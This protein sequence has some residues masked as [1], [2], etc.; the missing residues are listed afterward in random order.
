MKELAEFL[1]SERQKRNLTLGSMSELSGIS[2]GMLDRFE[3]GDLEFLGSALLIR[4]IIRGYCNALEIDP[5]PI[6]ERVAPS[7]DS[8]NF[9]ELGIKK[10]A[11][12]MK[13]L[14]KKKRRM[15]ASLLIF[16]VATAAVV[17][18]G[19]WISQKRASL[20][21]PLPAERILS[22]EELPPELVQKLAS[23]EPKRSELRSPAG[24]PG[25]EPGTT[26]YNSETERAIM[27]ADRNIGETG[28]S[29]AA[30]KAD[31]PQA[32]AQED[33]GEMTAEA[34]PPP[35]LPRVALSNSMEAVAE[36]KPA[37]LPPEAKIYVFAVKANA[38]T[39]VQVRID[40]RNTRSAMLYPGD[41]R[42]WSAQKGMQVVIGNAGGVSMKW[43]EQP[44]D[45]P[46]EPGRVL[47]F[48]LPDQITSIGD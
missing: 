22:Q 41:R 46:R 12:Q 8:L 29:R 18:A 20:Y 48:R 36:D 6:C 33:T 34:Q 15:N 38:K 24:V 16:A 1:K 28:M 27:E 40:D 31:E 42:E 32:Q 13:L 26:A 44:I 10:Y 3:A 39:W 23:S 14:R 4:Y 19:T 17:Y 30:G 2:T 37:E 21:A 35:D 47:R 45:A 9:Q 43:D 25:N 7:L 11:C 5:R